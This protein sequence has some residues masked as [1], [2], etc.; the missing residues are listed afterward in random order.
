MFLFK[1]SL[2]SIYKSS[3][4]RKNVAESLGSQTLNS[5]VINKLCQSLNDKDE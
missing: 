3:E 1:F 5:E 2:N 4:V